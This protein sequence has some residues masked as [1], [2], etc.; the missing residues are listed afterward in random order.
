[1]DEFAPQEPPQ[2]VGSVADGISV[3]VFMVLFAAACVV[4]TVFGMML[5]FLTDSC[6]DETCSLGISV[7][8]M[9]VT[10]VGPWLA[11]IGSIAWLIFRLIKRKRLFWVPIAGFGIALAIAVFGTLLAYLGA[12]F[13]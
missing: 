8:G 12:R 9:I 5:A 10:I 2:R 6:T 7:T 13:G 11:F 3:A 1:M 4:L